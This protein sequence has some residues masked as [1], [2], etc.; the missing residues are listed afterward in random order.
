ML[1]VFFC[2]HLGNSSWWNRWSL[3]NKW[4]L[5]NLGVLN[6]M[7]DG[8]GLG[9]V[10]LRGLSDVENECFLDFE[11]DIIP[12]AMAL[13]RFRYCKTVSHFILAKA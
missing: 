13:G 11:K 12:S 8:M 4:G 2:G 10:G 6:G 1:K 3:I 7:G 9:M 5:C